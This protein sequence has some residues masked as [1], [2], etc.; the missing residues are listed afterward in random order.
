MDKGTLYFR[1]TLGTFLKGYFLSA[2]VGYMSRYLYVP[3][4]A[5]V[6]HS[7]LYAC[8]LMARH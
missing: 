1:N 5:K 8:P 2:N 6:S 4:Q 7:S 3:T